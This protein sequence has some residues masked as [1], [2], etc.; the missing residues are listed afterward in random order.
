MIHIQE[1]KS[2][3]EP[4]QMDWVTELPPSGKTSSNA[5]LLISDRYR[6]TPILLPCH[7]DDTAMDTALLLLDGAISHTALFKNIIS[8]RDPTFK[9]ELWTNLHGL[10]G[11]KLYFIQHKILKLMGWKKEGFK[12]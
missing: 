4:F 6:E 8:D 1:P 3:W 7:K 5:F 10:F 2:P 11:T 12:L 9:S